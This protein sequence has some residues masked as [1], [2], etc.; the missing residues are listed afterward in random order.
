MKLSGVVEKIRKSGTIALTDIGIGGNIPEAAAREMVEL[1]VN[2]DNILKIVTTHHADEYKVPL[3]NLDIDAD[4]LVNVPEGQDPVTTDKTG[5]SNPGKSIEL[6]DTNSFLEMFFSTLRSAKGRKA[7]QKIQK[8]WIKK[9]SDNIAKVGFVGTEYVANTRDITKI[10][11]GWVQTAKDYTGSHKVNAHDHK[12]VG[13]EIVWENFLK[14][15]IKAL[16]AKYKS[17]SV[18][19][20]MNPTDYESLVDEVAEKSGGINYLITGKIPSFKGYKIRKESN[21]PQGHVMFTNLKNLQYGI[22]TS[23]TNQKDINSLKRVL[24][25]VYGLANGYEIAVEDALVIAWDQGGA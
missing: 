4:V 3:S 7:Q 16:P 15:I 8:K 5:A 10:N 17:D 2:Q 9:I 1:L 13:D 20:I 19:L 18:E 23:V 21:M 25:Y 24:T 22:N 14:A 6:K 11:K 12:N